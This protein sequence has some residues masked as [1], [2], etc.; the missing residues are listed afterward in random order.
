MQAPISHGKRLVITLCLLTL[1]SCSDTTNTGNHTAKQPV[2]VH[3]FSLQQVPNYSVTRRFAGVLVPSQKTDIGFE[4]P[5]KVAQLLVNNGDSVNKGQALA[6]LDTE[7]LEIERL[8]LN[9]KLAETSARQ[10]LIAN[11]LKRQ[12]SLELD[13]FASQQRLDELH[14]EQD[15]LIAAR[16]QLRAGLSTLESKIRKAVLVA[17]FDAIVGSRLTD[18]GTVVSAGMP[19]FRL[20]QERGQEARMGVPHRFS[21]LLKPGTSQTLLINGER[22]EAS[23]ITLGADINPVTHTRTVRLSL[24]EINASIAGQL[25]YLEV[26][27]KIEQVG[28]WAPLSGMTDSLRGLWNIYTLKADNKGNFVTEPRAVKIAYSRDN[29]VFITGDLGAADMMIAD[30]M[31]RVVP[32]QVVTTVPT[33]NTAGNKGAAL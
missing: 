29:K 4:L 16:D 27:E 7:L 10:T 8:Q 12:T 9:A 13:G 18:E 19:V 32:G 26:N 15:A 24:P 20:L 33:H 21:H 14:S 3:V 31:H 28:Y 25:A 2:K 17:P 23:V 5:G 1:A 30:G 11:N 6:R 22:I